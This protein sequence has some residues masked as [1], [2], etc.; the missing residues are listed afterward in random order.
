[1]FKGISE[2]HLT[3]VR[4]LK[5]DFPVHGVNFLENASKDLLAKS[6]F[7]RPNRVKIR[8]ES[9]PNQVRVRSG[10][11]EVQRGGSSWEAPVPPRKVLTLIKGR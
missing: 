7:S 5:H 6:A 3:K 1:M 10:G 2:P 9:G 4:L 11:G 8:S